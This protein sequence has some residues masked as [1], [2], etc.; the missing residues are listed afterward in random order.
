MQ[1]SISSLDHNNPSHLCNPIT[2]LLHCNNSPETTANMSMNA[3]V[4][5]EYGDVSKI[6]HKKVP[7]PDQPRGHDVLISSVPPPL[8]SP[9]PN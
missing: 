2:S 3:L 1:L 7:K 6:V 5:E 9:T 4:V 8:S